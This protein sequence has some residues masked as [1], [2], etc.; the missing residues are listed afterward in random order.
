MKII[1]SPSKTQSDSE[2]QE[3]LEHPKYYAFSKQIIKEIKNYNRDD[4]S[5]MMHIKGKLLEETYRLYKEFKV[6]RKELIPAI[7]LDKGVVY[8]C[9]NLDDFSEKESFVLFLINS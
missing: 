4:L 5:K 8:D 9:F 2:V 6:N 3:G 7:K 1:L